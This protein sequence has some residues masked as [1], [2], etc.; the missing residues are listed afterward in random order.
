MQAIS[1]G[2]N[3][4]ANPAT[5]ALELLARDQQSLKA[6][7]GTTGSCRGNRRKKCSYDLSVM[8]QV[9]SSIEDD[10]AFD[11]P[12]I[13]WCSDDEEEESTRATAVTESATALFLPSKRHKHSHHHQ[14]EKHQDRPQPPSLVRSH[15]FPSNLMS[16]SEG[17][18]FSPA[19]CTN[20][21]NT[22]EEFLTSKVSILG[23]HHHLSRDREHPSPISPS[24][25]SDPLSSPL[26]SFRIG[27]EG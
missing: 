19:P 8:F 3:R 24:N 27:R 21:L 13:E 25:K 20:Y 17:R 2:S 5:R 16:L 9:A 14:E 18:L 6:H 7:G 23:H 15:A 1:L 12:P 4:D 22:K 11:F 10:N 26:I